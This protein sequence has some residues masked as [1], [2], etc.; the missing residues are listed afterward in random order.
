MFRRMLFRVLASAA[1]FVPV[2]PVSAQRY[3][4]VEP[5]SRV[6]DTDSGG[7]VALQP[8]ERVWDADGGVNG[9]VVVPEKDSWGPEIDPKAD[10]E[11]LRHDVDAL[12]S[13]ED[14]SDEEG[15]EY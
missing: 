7:N 6:M 4:I 8:G 11:Q 13:A 3:D 2:L 5:S 14:A 1:V 15:D 10:A 12:E 9:A